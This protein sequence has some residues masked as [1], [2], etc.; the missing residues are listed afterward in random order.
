MAGLVQRSARVEFGALRDDKLQKLLVRA[1]HLRLRM[2]V[3]LIG[4]MVL[5]FSLLDVPDWRETA[6]WA[7]IA[8]VF[9]WFAVDAVWIKRIPITSRFFVRY[10]P[11]MII[12]Q[13]IAI[14]ITGGLDSPVIPALFVPVAIA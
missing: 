11:L 4:G 13:S 14:A 6:L 7:F 8:I 1:F 5:L 2:A 9:C 12:V 3:P 10:L